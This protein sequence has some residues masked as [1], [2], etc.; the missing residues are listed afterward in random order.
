MR[1]LSVVYCID[2][3]ADESDTLDSLLSRADEILSTSSVKPCV[4]TEEGEEISST[5]DLRE[6]LLDK[7]R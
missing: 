3:V 1:V 2:V 4:Y 6:Y 7:K 5:E